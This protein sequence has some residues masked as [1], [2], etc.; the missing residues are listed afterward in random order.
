MYR[1]LDKFIIFV[2]YG[3]EELVFGEVLWV[4]YFDLDV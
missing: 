1:E 2:Q 3:D 4:I